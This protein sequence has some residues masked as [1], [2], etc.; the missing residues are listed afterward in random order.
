VRAGE[1]PG[2]GAAAAHLL[3]VLGAARA[4]LSVEALAQRAQRSVTSV[5][6]LVDRLH[7]RQ[8]VRLHGP[9]GPSLARV[10]LTESARARLHALERDRRERLE[11]YVAALDA[12]R[13]LRLAGALHLL[14]R[15]LDE[16]LAFP[17]PIHPTTSLRTVV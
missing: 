2:L 13:R 9:A 15:R 11:R 8:L 5:S 7:H 12:P 17:S 16:E 6:R 14:S 4:P 1:E 3:L 10:E